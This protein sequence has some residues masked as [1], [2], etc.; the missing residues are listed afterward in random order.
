MGFLS[1]CRL[2]TVRLHS[3]AYRCC[4]KVHLLNFSSPEVRSTDRSEFSSQTMHMT[5][6][7]PI[8]QIHAMR[9][10]AGLCSRVN[11]NPKLCTW[12]YLA[13]KEREAAELAIH[14]HVWQTQDQKSRSH[15][16]PSGDVDHTSK[17]AERHPGEPDLRTVEKFVHVRSRQV[18]LARSVYYCCLIAARLRYEIRR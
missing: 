7:L 9:T 11:P 6:P 8:L 1:N 13:A 17:A 15:Q 2:Q 12:P 5:V 4:Y 3:L 10:Y 14:P 16:P 18:L